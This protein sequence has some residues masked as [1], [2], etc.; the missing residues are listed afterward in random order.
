M[1]LSES[2]RFLLSFILLLFFSVSASAQITGFTAYSDYSTIQMSACTLYYD[3]IN[4]TNLENSA[5]TF[6]VTLSGSA[7]SF[8]T[9][10][11]SN[12]MIL[13]GRSESLLIILSPD[14]SKS[15]KYYLNVYFETLEEEKILRQTIEVLPYYNL[16]LIPKYENFSSTICSNSS[17]EFDFTIANTGAFPERYYIH[18]RN[19]SGRTKISDTSFYLNPNETRNVRISYLGL[20][21]GNYKSFIRVDTEKSRLTSKFDFSFY[22][23][24]CLP[25]KEPLYLRVKAFVLANLKIIKIILLVLLII[26]LILILIF[27]LKKNWERLKSFVVRK[28]HQLHVY[29]EKKKALKELS[30]KPYYKQVIVEKKQLSTS[31]SKKHTQVESS[32]KFMIFLLILCCILLLGIILFLVFTT[33]PSIGK[34]FLQFFSN[35]KD[36]ITLLISKLGSQLKSYSNQSNNSYSTKIPSKNA[37]QKNINTQ[38]VSRSVN[39]TRVGESKNFQSFISLYKNYIL[40]GIGLAA[41][42]IIFS[43]FFFSKKY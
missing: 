8:S 27:V 23:S 32:N 41:I 2:I 36:K 20:N 12:F 1:K 40:L 33:F 29:I 26:L 38:A 7:A 42:L 24:S 10:S 34:T 13:P 9:L 4:I 16:A 37:S 35:L 22:V 18:F 5:L 14:C 43:I 3:V 30:K 31:K 11:K 21:P 25:P 28:K 15:G 17:A 6:R 39:T 19:I